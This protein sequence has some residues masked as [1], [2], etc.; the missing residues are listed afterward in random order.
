MT[1]TARE[2]VERI[3]RETLERLRVQPVVSGER[4]EPPQEELPE[5]PSG[6]PVAQEW[7]LFRHERWGGYSPQATR[8]DSL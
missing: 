1:E 3:H 5:A 6:S 2:L 7:E 4:P 8:D